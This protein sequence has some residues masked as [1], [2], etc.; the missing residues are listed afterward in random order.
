MSEL[1]FEAYGPK[2]DPAEYRSRAEIEAGFAALPAPPQR[3]GTLARIVRRH[4][5]GQRE[6]LSSARLT[7][8]EGLP[9]DGWNRRPPRKI[10][11]QLAVIRMDIASLL[12]AEQSV[13]LAGDQLFVDL[14]VSAA[15]LPAGTR[16]RVGGA[17][18]EMTPEP[19]DGCLKFKDRF[20]QD[21]LRFVQEKATRSE[22]RRGVYWKVIE[23]GDIAEGCP[24]EV[25]EKPA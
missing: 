23:A 6:A 2:G 7:P 8:E 15:N 10:E 13:T 22:N 25:V 4:P 3:R 24:I 17:L 12:A 20:G 1:E 19:H 18:V 16:L 5:D 11:A 21:A 9:G 14:D